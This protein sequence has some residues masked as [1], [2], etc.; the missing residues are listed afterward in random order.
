MSKIKTKLA[1]IVKK[2][3]YKSFSDREILIFSWIWA[4]LG[5]AGILLM[6][7]EQIEQKLTTDENALLLYSNWVHYS[8]LNAQSCLAHATQLDSL[9]S[10]SQKSQYVLEQFDKLGIKA[11][12]QNYQFSLP[13]LNR[14]G[15]N[16]YAILR[17]PR[18][19]G[20]EALVLSA[21]WES[22]G[23]G[24]SNGVGLMLSLAEHFSSGTHWA[25]D[26]IFLITEGGLPAHYAWLSAYHQSQ[27]LAG[28]EYLQLR[29]GAIQ[30]A[31]DLELPGLFPSYSSLQVSYGGPNGLLPNQDLVATT[32]LSAPIYGREFSMADGYDSGSYLGRLAV[33]ATHFRNM[34]VCSPTKPQGLFLTYDV[35][36]VSVTGIPGPSRLSLIDIGQQIESTF[37][38]LNN[39]LERL[40]HAT[41]FYLLLT[42]TTFAPLAVFLPVALI[43]ALLP[44]LVALFHLRV[45]QPKP[46]P[47]NSDCKL[48]AYEDADTFP[49]IQFKRKWRGVLLY[50][51]CLLSSVVCFKLVTLGLLHFSGDANNQILCISV[52]GV[53]SVAIS[54]ILTGFLNPCQDSM[55]EMRLISLLISGIFAVILAP[56]NAGLSLLLGISALPYSLLFLPLGWSRPAAF[57]LNPQLLF[58]LLGL[59]WNDWD[60]FALEAA[61]KD[62]L[63]TQHLLGGWVVPI[64]LLVYQPMNNA[65]LLPSSKASTQ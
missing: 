27:P 20:T 33:V 26:I 57:L 28:I 25:K 39:L 24:N 29:S 13:Y 56:V 51:G 45:P 34:A 58:V 61:I 32:T 50:F 3:G 55:H 63:V 9:P 7:H 11:A 53:S 14:K 22:Q 2:V 49:E 15:V 35:D 46:E 4:F 31:V 38:S 54:Y 40:H 62:I 6:P 5:L 10:T 59:A 23:A 18:G 43:F 47:E 48:D 64:A 8:D 41:R 21:D 16:T 44:I 17:A 60:I 12:T 36:A 52:L 1:A 65:F 19:D 42:P 30:L 37:R